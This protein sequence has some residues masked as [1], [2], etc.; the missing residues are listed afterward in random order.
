MSNDTTPMP[1]D[2]EERLR[3]EPEAVRADLETV[4]DRLD[5]ADAAARGEAAPDA[6]WEAL[7]REHPEL[8][9]TPTN[10][11]NPAA[12][13]RAERAP[14]SRG[15]SRTAR[16]PD[17]RQWA[18]AMSVALAVLVLVGGL[19]FWRQPVT[20]TAPPGQQRTVTLPD[21]STAELNSGTTLAYTRGFQAWP[22]VEAERRTVR[23]TGEAF[24]EVTEGA[25]PFAIETENAQVTVLGT[26]F[27]VQARSKSTSTPETEV[28]VVD[29]RVQVAAQDRP[30]RGVL[31]AEPGQSSRVT[32]TAAGPTSPQATSVDHVLAWRHDGFAAR[33][34]PLA[35]VLR[36]LERRYNVVLRLH[37]SVERTE[38]AVSLYYPQATKLETILHDLCTARDLNYRPTSRGFEIFAASEAR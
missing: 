20:I 7:V 22:F 2:L 9:A 18:V 23:L 3:E 34:Q 13:N 21:G 35:S 24:F 15:R 6:A 33:A 17:R 28:T 14:A 19:W 8:D 32:G 37:E 4:W 25:R 27:N 5:S 12:P 29:G 10:G 36:D 30:D 38:G 11:T 1:D 16:R 31:L 26:R